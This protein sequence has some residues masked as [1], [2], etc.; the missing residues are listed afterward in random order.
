[1]NAPSPP[2]AA[3]HTLPIRPIETPRGVRAWLVEDQSAPLVALRFAFRG[4]ASQ[5]PA[6][7]A[8]LA[9]MM[10]GLLDEGA[11]PYDSAAFQERLDEFAVELSFDADRD[12][13]GGGLRTLT[14]HRAEAFEMLRLALVEPRF[15]DDAVER[16]R[17]Q[18]SA[19]LK[20]EAKDPDSIVGRAFAEAAFPN[21]PYGKSVN[22]SLETVPSLGRADIAALNRRLI[23]RDNLVIGIVGAID[24][25]AAAAALD[26]I[27]GDLPAKAE[28]AAI[29][30]VA[31]ARI[32][33]TVISHLDI[34]QT[35]I[36]FGRAGVA[37]K[38]ADFIAAMVVNHIFGGGTFQSRLFKEVREKR[39][40]A[41]SVSSSLIA[42]EHSALLFGGTSTKNERAGEALQVI[43]EQIASLSTEGPSDEEIEKAKKYITGSY[44]LRFDSST[45][46]AAQLVHM[47][48]DE[49][50][51]DW[52]QRRNALVN[53][54]SRADVTRVAHRLF[55]DGALLVAAAG[56]PRGL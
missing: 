18:I 40:L 49:L 39:G 23:A 5:D 7:K 24:A 8:G 12:S 22:G 51:L 11:G 30:T 13:L 34:P 27:F 15:D 14:R 17:A 47:Q 50:G 37:R 3:P 16:I 4:G 6:D 2:A 52:M 28:L 55:G 35:A 53:A 25:A 21:H 41:Y 29:P 42:N 44:P 19:G 38:D 56:Q 1:M 31:P 48:L 26:R 32:G 46:I 43:R 9:N 45:K 36:R 33:E 20:H 54:V 10:S